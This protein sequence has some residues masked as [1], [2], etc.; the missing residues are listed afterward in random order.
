MISQSGSASAKDRMLIAVF[1]GQVSLACAFVEGEKK[2]FKVD[3]EG[4]GS[5]WD[6]AL[7]AGAL[8][9][10]GCGN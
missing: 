10:R 6:S 1:D 2:K 5:C 4:A 7:A 8:R 9:V 3:A